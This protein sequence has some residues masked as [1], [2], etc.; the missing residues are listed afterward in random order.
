MT[1]TDGLVGIDGNFKATGIDGI[2][3]VDG[4]DGIQGIMEWKLWENGINHIIDRYD[5]SNGITDRFNGAV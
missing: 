2:E 3:T 5:E 1:G 4:T